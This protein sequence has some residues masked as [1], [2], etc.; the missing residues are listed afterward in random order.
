MP[1][2]AYDIRPG[3]AEREKPSDLRKLTGK[4]KGNRVSI[5]IKASAVATGQRHARGTGGSEFEKPWPVRKAK[6]KN[7]FGDGSVFLK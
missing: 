4:G 5:L 3:L 7:A 1:V 6:R 2:K